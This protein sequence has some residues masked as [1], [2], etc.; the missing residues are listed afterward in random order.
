MP[1]AVTIENVGHAFEVPCLEVVKAMPADGLTLATMA[2]RWRGRPWRSSSRSARRWRSSVISTGW[3]S[4]ASRIA[5]T[6]AT[7]AVC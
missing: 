7:D 3:P 6:A 1:R 4:L 2:G 5:A